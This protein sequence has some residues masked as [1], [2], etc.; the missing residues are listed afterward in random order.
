MT[1]RKRLKK[2][3]AKGQG[4]LEDPSTGDRISPMQQTPLFCLNQISS[5]YS[6]SQCERN[7]KAH[8][9]DR[10]YTL[11]Q[12]TW[13]QIQSA[14]RHGLGSEKIPTNALG[15]ATLPAGVT[16]DV[17]LLAIRFSGMKPMVGYRSERVFHILFLDR[18]FSLYNHG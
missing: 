4:K 9:A 18:N 7:E 17:Q 16:Q 6:L 1:S 14:D 10:L 8:F 11:S 3:K 2:L 15:T 5:Q 12:M 13:A